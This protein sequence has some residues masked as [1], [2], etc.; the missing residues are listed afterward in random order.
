LALYQDKW[1][2]QETSTAIFNPVACGTAIGNTTACPLATYGAAIY[3]ANSATIRGIE[4]NATAA[5]THK[6]TADFSINY[7]DSK[8]DS[9]QNNTYS[10]FTGGLSYYNGNHISRVPVYQGSFDS[11]YKDH[12]MAD[13]DW[14]AHGVVLFTGPMYESEINLAQTNA[15]AR[16]NAEIGITRGGLTLELYAKN[17]FND[18][19]WDWASR[20]PSLNS[21][22]DNFVTNMGVLVQAPDR[23]DFGL[24]L[25]DKF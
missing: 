9:Y 6:W 20:V 1:I 25:T 2:D 23:Q 7:T 22:S 5:I 13:W 18:R 3:L 21:P 15:Y 11:T 12:L 19:N 14:Y 4:F 17:L 24:K 16:V 10:A 8:W